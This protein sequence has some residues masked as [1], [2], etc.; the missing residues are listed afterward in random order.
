MKTIILALAFSALTSNAAFSEEAESTLVE[1]P[2]DYVMSLLRL[3][4]DYAIEDETTKIDMDNFLLT[5]INDELEESDYKS[6]KV[7]PK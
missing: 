2:S 5:C 6:V 1:A 7:L 4:K 3:C